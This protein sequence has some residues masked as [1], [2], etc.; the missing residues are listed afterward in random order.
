MNTKRII[1]LIGLALLGTLAVLAV[2]HLPSAI[3]HLSSPNPLSA[4]GHWL[5]AISSGHLHLLGAGGLVLAAAPVVITE[6]Q[7]RE[8]QGI[9]GE[10][11]GGW[12]EIKNL[13]ATLKSVQSENAEL[14]QQFTDVRRLLATRHA[15]PVTR[16]SK[17]VSDECAQHLAAAF[18][19]HCERSGKLEALAS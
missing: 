9:L 5:S 17:Q 19:V 14:K 16:H 18:I 3:C 12:G 11:Q 4:I 7:L 8:F 13:P 2:C 6:E 1:S 10:L 15:S